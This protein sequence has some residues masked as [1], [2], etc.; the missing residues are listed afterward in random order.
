MQKYMYQTASELRAKGCDV[1]TVG[2]AI[3]RLGT[4]VEEHGITVNTP[5]SP[6]PTPISLIRMT[7]EVCKLTQLIDVARPDI[8]H[9]VNKHSWN[10][11][12]MRSIARQIPR[13]PIVH[14]FHDPVGHYGDAVRHAVVRYHKMVQPML[15]GIIVHS[16]VARTQTQE[17]LR[18]TCPV[19]EIPLGLAPWRPYA[20]PAPRA[21]KCALIFGR[22]NR[23]KG[24]VYYPAIL[25]RLQQLDPDIRVVIAGKASADMSKSLLHDIVKRPNVEL[26]NEYV[27]ESELS[28]YFESADLVLAPYLSTS[29]SGVIL[30]AF[31]RGR[32]VLAFDIEGVRDYVP[33]AEH[34]IAPF[35][36]DAYARAIVKLLNNRSLCTQLGREGWDYGGS[37]FTPELMA[38]GIMQAYTALEKSR[39]SAR[40][41]GWR[42]IMQ[43][44]D[45]RDP[46]REPRR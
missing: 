39:P 38:S 12:A 42:Q 24:C 33:Y 14:T 32:A 27:P 29:Q 10:Y 34:L 3:L 43:R 13:T 9:F 22:L 19:F 1:R 28:A 16:K 21:S 5:D 40:Q 31:S 46:E 11:F 17:K 4:T 15:S 2:S 41:G 45:S 7:R 18:P 26:R 8:V 35:D 6:I 23:Y 20:S 44:N 36:I 25:D 37:R 30:D